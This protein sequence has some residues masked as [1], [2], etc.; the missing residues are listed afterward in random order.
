MVRVRILII[1]PEGDSHVPFVLPHLA[2]HGA[3]V[4]R[5]ELA[6]MPQQSRLAA[7]LGPMHLSWTGLL[8]MNQQRVALEELT[9]LWNRRRGAAHSMPYRP[10]PR[11]PPAI[12]SFVQAETRAGM[13]G[14]WKSLPALQVNAPEVNTVAEYKPYQLQVARA[15]G[16]R[17]PDTCITNDPDA[18]RQFLDTHKGRV[19]SKTLSRAHIAQAGQHWW[20]YSTKNP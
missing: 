5:L 6:H 14:I 7:H 19:I 13:E 15:S 1:A 12:Q 20:L 16:L 4:F 9:S 3:E 11:L 8:E 2:R 18:A 17:I 10:D